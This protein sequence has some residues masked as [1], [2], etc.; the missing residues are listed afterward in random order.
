MNKDTI[1]LISAMGKKLGRMRGV[2]SDEVE[3]ELF[4]LKRSQGLIKQCRGK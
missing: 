1:S 2:E 4:C 3:Q